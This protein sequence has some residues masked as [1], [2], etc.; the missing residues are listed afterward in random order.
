METQNERPFAVVT[1]AASGIGLELA[2]QFARNGYDLLIASD[3]E[4]IFEAQ[5][6]LLTYGT[7]VEG[8]E[9][10]LGTYNGVELLAKAI[11]RF[12]KPIDALV[13]NS[14]V[15]TD[16]SFSETDLRKEI[17]LINLNILSTVHLTKSLLPDMMDNERGRI[18]FV[19]SLPSTSSDSCNAVLNG[20][21]GFIVSFVESIRAE[22]KEHGISL[23]LLQQGQTEHQDMEGSGNNEQDPED[24]A[25]LGFEALIS[26]QESVYPANLMSKIQGWLARKISEAGFSKH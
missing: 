20:T 26:G 17:N 25:R 12:G 3:N 22:A 13:I 8:V 2:R 14:G 18:L 6:E 23:T 1:G 19:T 7:N 24:I 15:G 5:D 10:I 21:R 11:R 9:T 4:A 16:G